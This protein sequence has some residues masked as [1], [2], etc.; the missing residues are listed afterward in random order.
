V[1]LR[2]VPGGRQRAG[3]LTMATKAP[4]SESADLCAIVL[5]L[6]Q[7]W[8]RLNHPEARMRAEVELGDWREINLLSACEGALAEFRRE[9][10]D[11]G[12]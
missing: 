12:S 10:G 2:Y 6:C 9:H 8:L 1:A 5:V 7:E 4:S 3:G 11:G